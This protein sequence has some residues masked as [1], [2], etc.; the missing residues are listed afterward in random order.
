MT[1][2]HATLLFSFLTLLLSVQT[3]MA[4]DM[5]T[6]MRSNGKIYVVV[7]VL[8][9]IFAGILGF[10]VYLERRIKKLESKK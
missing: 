7:F 8:A 10:L 6:E 3:A 4:Q 9:T 5:A 1:R 2:L